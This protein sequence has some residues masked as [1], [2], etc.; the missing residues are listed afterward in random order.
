MRQKKFN[1]RRMK[2]GKKAAEIPLV[3][4]GYAYRGNPTRRDRTEK[5]LLN[6][7]NN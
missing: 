5:R 3:P 6:Y 2:V 7:R 1:D 4:G